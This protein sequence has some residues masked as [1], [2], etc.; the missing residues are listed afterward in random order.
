MMNSSAKDLHQP[1]NEFINCPPASL[2]RPASESATNLFRLLLLPFSRGGA[3]G[4]RSEDRHL[5]VATWPP[6]QA[7]SSPTDATGLKEKIY[8]VDCGTSLHLQLK[9]QSLLHI[10]FVAVVV[11]FWHLA[12]SRFG[13][14]CRICDTTFNEIFLSTWRIITRLS[15]CS[16]RFV[17]THVAEAANSNGKHLLGN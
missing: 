17:A 10:V 16:C 12:L 3:S 8:C 15:S 5:P 11:A 7:R 14:S 2:K 9:L 1:I 4:G 6:S 13:E